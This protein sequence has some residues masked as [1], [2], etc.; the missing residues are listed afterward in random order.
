M[1]SDDVEMMK[2]EEFPK[3]CKWPKL[4]DDRASNDGTS[5]PLLA[6]VRRTQKV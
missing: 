4:D 2:T 3:G 5:K 6:G 1:S